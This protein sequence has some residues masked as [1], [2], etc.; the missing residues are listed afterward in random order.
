MVRGWPW[1]VCSRRVGDTYAAALIGSN[2][3]T[4]YEKLLVPSQVWIPRGYDDALMPRHIDIR[5]EG[6]VKTKARRASEND[7]PRSQHVAR[8]P[9]LQTDA[10]TSLFL[11]HQASRHTSL[12]QYMYKNKKGEHRR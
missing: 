1:G 11:Q 7:N 12:L 9:R 5:A 10:A 3:R 2:H 6:V 4:Y 8:N